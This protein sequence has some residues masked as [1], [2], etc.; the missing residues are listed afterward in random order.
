M[1]DARRARSFNHLVATIAEGRLH[2]LATEAYRKAV[3]RLSEVGEGTATIT[4]KLKLRAHRGA[5]E[6][7]GEVTT[8]L[9]EPRLDRTILYAT[10]EGFL[11]ATHPKQEEMQFRDVS[12]TAGGTTFRAPGA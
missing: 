11:T 6:A 8:K 3:E 12:A 5:Y 4:V 2:D 1:A 10:P 7:D 9:P